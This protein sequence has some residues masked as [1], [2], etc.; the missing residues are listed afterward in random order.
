M[1]SRP[2]VAAIALIVLVGT[3]S[4]VFLLSRRDQPSGG[5]S[6]DG[7]P[8]KA[9]VAA[10]PLTSLA[11]RVRGLMT[12]GTDLLTAEA[13]TRQWV[14]AVIDRDRKQPR[15][16][17][18]AALAHPDWAVNWTGAMAVARYGPAGKEL[19]TALVPLLGADNPWVRRAAAQGAAYV[20]EG[21]E[22][23]VPALRDAALDPEAT[24]R[25]PAV[26]TLARRSARHLDLLPVFV[27]ALEDENRLVRGAA[28][29]GI[30]Q[31]EIQER[32]PEE[33]RP[34]I[35][36]ALT[37]RLD[38]ESSEVR[39]YAAMAIGRAGTA[40]APALEALLG[41][42]DDEHALVRTQASTA[43]GSL[44][45]I[46]IPVLKDALATDRGERASLL[47]WS[48]RLIGDP[49]VPV[50]E[51]ATRHPSAVVRVHAAMKLW[52]LERNTESTVD[53]LIEALASTDKNAL[54]Q[55]ASA[56]GR[57][58]PR[59]VKAV[60]VLET[61][62]EHEEALVRDAVRGALRVIAPGKK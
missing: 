60:P 6:G 49:A 37:R 29:Y 23:M 5:A 42:L 22:T 27:R 56:L 4:A 62:R 1:R 41:L 32:L 38:D 54:Y 13:R 47:L 2:P 44:D 51:E 61:L 34:K 20:G 15:D 39:M 10:E 26:R 35:V 58:G 53:L 36:A 48:L 24:V 25:E 57:L 12:G 33:A 31:I 19:A 17:I 59:A 50:I 40:A 43:L 11:P 14:D 52:E 18:H 30:A 3:I 21:F 28:T 55:A 45:A 9:D 16:V 7:G 8:T 46:A